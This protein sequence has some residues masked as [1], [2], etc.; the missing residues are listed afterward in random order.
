MTQRQPFSSPPPDGGRSTS[1]G[2]PVAWRLVRCG[3]ARAAEAALF[4]DLDALVP[5]GVVPVQPVRVLVASASLR[6]HL[7]RAL[8]RHRGGGVLGV[9]VETLFSAAV[10]VR[11]RDG[12]GPPWGQAVLPVLVARV[13]STEPA[14]AE[15][16]DALDDGYAA[17]AR[18]VRDLLD[19][20]FDPAHGDAIDERLASLDGDPDR[21]ARARAVVRVASRVAQEL[22]SLGVDAGGAVYADAANR[23][24]ARP[25]LLPGGAVLIHGVADAT[26][27]LTDFLRALLRHRGAR[28][29]LPLPPDPGNAS[30]VDAGAVFA[31]RFALRLAGAC[32][33]EERIVP[34]STPTIRA[35]SST[36]VD[37]EA[38]AVAAEVRT[39]LDDGATPESIGIVA[40]NL[41][42]FAAALRRHLDRLGVPWSGVGA[43]V[44]GGGAARRVAAARAVLVEREQVRVDR[45]L[46][47]LGSLRQAADAEPQATTSDRFDLR[48]ALRARGAVR[49]SD[50]ARLD[51]TGVGPKDRVPLPARRGIVGEGEGAMLA[52][53]SVRGEVLHQAVKAASRLVARLAQ[54]P[55]LAPVEEH[56]KQVREVLR[57][58]L[59]WFPD[60]PGDT[61]AMQA[62]AALEGDLPNGW[63]VSRSEAEYLVA[64]A[65]DGAGA[66]PLGGEGG[67]VVVL[68][69]T[70]ARGRTF[71]H[72]FLIGLNR[73]VFPR[74]VAEDPLLPDAVRRAL[75]V[76]L[77]DLAL[78]RDGHDEERFLFAWLTSASPRV[79][80]SWEH[81]DADGRPVAS[82]PLV[83]RL[84]HA[85][86]PVAP[87]PPR[88]AP[89]DAYEAAIALSVRGMR[90]EAAPLWKD[91]LPPQVA[92][93]RLAIL[94]EVD[95]DRRTR[96]GPVRALG[97]GPWLGF[98]GEATPRDPR[99]APLF[100]TTLEAVARCPWQ[101]FLRRVLRLEAPPDP[102]GALPEIDA[103]LVGNV[104]HGVLEAIVTRAFETAGRKRRGDDLDALRTAAPV[105]VPWPD[106]DA[107]ADLIEQI[108]REQAREA[109]V[110]LP[111]FATVLGEQARAA[112]EV[113]REVDWAEGVREVIA[114]EW[115]GSWA[116]P[117]GQRLHFR[118]D[119]IDPG[120]GGGLV[121]TDY[122]SGK[123]IHGGKREDTRRRHFLCEVSEG[124]RLQVVL[125]A[126]A[127]GRGRYLFLHPEAAECARE[128]PV[129]RDDQTFTAAFDEAVATTRAAWEQGV[130]PPRLEEAGE[131]R[132]PRDCEYCDVREACLRGDSGARAR[133]RFVGEG[134]GETE[135]W[136]ATFQ[137][138]WWLGRKTDP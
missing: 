88:Q 61:V 117:D 135:A 31:E 67:G 40:R 42:P 50:V 129:D 134:P 99:R 24:A 35:W 105:S 123:P 98:V 30:A 34:V 77:P 1:A 115:T 21:M 11:R 85:T 93:A 17:V 5:P 138:I 39:L 16:L 70:E 110:G 81:A 64:G 82:S 22:A 92:E 49:L 66:V 57:N 114:V 4:E 118:A 137:R 89:P 100:V 25:W 14:L 125:Y 56:L 51:L 84:R 44:P 78:K 101:A 68:D 63:T 62:L 71:E 13:A 103:V 43:T 73:D 48:L 55:E 12:L 53:R 15:Q 75:G 130:F 133:V 2:A 120:E 131:G 124:K 58:H 86:D 33:P 127:A 83:E 121:L 91:V 96:E 20:G 59:G 128:F 29:Y 136:H 107:L 108:A 109:G 36:G 116:L 37:G 54:W 27:A 132:E 111:G 38:R 97:P 46:D 102:V 26:G 72:L 23:L 19:A 104:V 79:Y 87:K 32:A 74:P 106:D 3:G 90:A 69:A 28:L 41:A 95:P 45:W 112:L 119:R 10:E 7:V 76:L 65:L 6:Q 47:A 113:A 80:L 94:E 122:K 9:H 18:S 8:V 126:R 52:R 60:L